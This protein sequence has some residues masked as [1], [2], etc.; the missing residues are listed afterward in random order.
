MDNWRWR[1]TAVFITI[2]FLFIVTLIP[3]LGLT[4]STGEAAQKPV[5][6]ETTN[7]RHKLARLTHAHH[8]I[9]L[10]ELLLINPNAFV[11][12]QTYTIQSGD[13]L[14]DIATKFNIPVAELISLNQ[15]TNPH[16]IFPGDVLL[17]PITQPK[18]PS[19]ERPSTN[20]LY[21]PLLTSSNK[22]PETPQF[23]TVQ[24]GDSL[25]QIAR[26]FGLTSQHIA[27]HNQLSNPRLIHTGTRLKIPQTTSFTP[28]IDSENQL[29]PATVDNLT[30]E[31]P[32]PV[33]PPTAVPIAPEP[34]PTATAVPQPTP[35]VPQN[36]PLIWPVESHSI[37]Q[38]FHWGH[39]GIDVVMPTGSNIVAAADG[40]VEVAAWH[41]Y[42]YGNVIVIDNYNGVRT[43]YAHL[44][45]F[46][47]AI[48]DTVTQ[49]QLIGLSGN[50]GN[51]TMPHLHMEVVIDDKLVNPCDYLPNGC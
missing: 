44:S 14:A 46:K 36:T 11:Q 2:I 31:Q 39:A 50:T 29:S 42:G 28:L 5:F 22:K 38:Y 15:L 8:A 13:R 37:I 45:E 6:V 25:D 19:E 4:Y 49:G 33:I 1:I 21:L 40:V 47:I 20:Q 35:V 16:L 43:L 26:R 51:S 7:G 41:A 24:R 32:I 34:M 10:H 27:D 3:F 23:Y 12:T 18:R 48:G 30:A 17:L 9:S